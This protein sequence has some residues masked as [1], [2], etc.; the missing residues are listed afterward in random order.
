MTA[1]ATATLPH[2]RPLG[3]LSPRGRQ[4]AQSAD[5]AIG[6]LNEEVSEVIGGLQAG[7]KVALHPTN[8]LYDGRTTEMRN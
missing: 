6:C 4:G 2:R 5:V 8:L 1:S 3:G 7:D